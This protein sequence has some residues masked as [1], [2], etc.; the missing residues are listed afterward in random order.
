MLTLSKQQ[1]R[2]LSNEPVNLSIVAL[3]KQMTDMEQLEI[4][5][6]HHFIGD[7][8]Y[9]REMFMPA[10]SVIVGKIHKKQ[11]LLQVQIGSVKVTSKEYSGILRG[12]IAYNSGP[13]AKRALL[14]LSDC[15]ISTVHEVSS[16]DL[17]KIE[18]ELIA[19]TFEDY[20]ESIQ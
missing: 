20:E 2:A 10:G 3:Q 19:D 9:V 11:H 5:V 4:K 6:W 15:F 18:A 16:T 13:G 12:P 14:A 1:I 7:H 8:I 17:D